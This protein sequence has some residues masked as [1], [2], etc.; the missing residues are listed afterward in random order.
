MVLNH[1][2]N[3]YTLFYQMIITMCVLKV[4]FII[5]KNVVAVVL[6][7]IFTEINEL[8]NSVGSFIQ[9]MAKLNN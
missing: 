2:S 8:E 5:Y 4:T 3:I 9:P 6:E 7:A 1:N